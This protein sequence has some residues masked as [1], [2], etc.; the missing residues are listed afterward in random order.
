[1]SLT[2]YGLASLIICSFVII[3]C[4][5][6][7]SS[8]K[9]KAKE[10]TEK[11]SETV[12]DGMSK[13]GESVEGGISKVGDKVGEMKDDAT[14]LVSEAADKVGEMKDSATDLVSK[15]ADKVE[16]G[17]E[18]GIEEAKK[19]VAP[20]SSDKPKPNASSTNNTQTS[21]PKP[22]ANV[23]TSMPD[24]VVFE[25]IPEESNVPAA[26][27]PSQSSTGKSNVLKKVEKP[28]GE[29]IKKEV[30]KITKPNSSTTKKTT[31]ENTQTEFGHT[32]FN[33]LLNKVVSRSGAV[34]YQLLKA[35]KQDLDSYCKSLEANAPASSWS[36]NEKLAYW[37]NA[38]NAYTLKLIVENYPLNS[39]T[40]LNGGKPWDRKWINL[41]SKTLSLND[42][43]NVIIRPTFKDARIHFAVNC[44]AKSCPPLANFAFTSRN[45]QSKMEA[46]T[47]SFINSS[48]NTITADKIVVS[49]IFD[50]Y[51]DD[52]G[53]LIGFIN[54]YSDV[55]VN[56]GAKV[57]YQEYDW[58][59]NG[60]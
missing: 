13:V 32:P 4:K 59:L 31:I 25:D 5:G 51:G 15:A 52:F 3:S 11:T 47:K 10:V 8:L 7:V 38:Y 54:K 45:V 48:F 18:V 35:N 9:D 12:S 27:T 49:K 21:K 30:G 56:A 22:K 1:M 34:D 16:S 14:D 57:E 50:W 28:T 17:V 20:S 39:I 60:K 26:S 6:D 55:K 43:E 53:D 33:T 23:P 42:I 24:D 19:I 36:R 44:A 40:D 46:L 29:V 2:K 58:G 41:D 37:L